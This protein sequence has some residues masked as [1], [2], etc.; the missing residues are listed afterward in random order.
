M[1]RVISFL[2]T[3]DRTLPDLLELLDLFALDR[4]F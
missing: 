3:Q 4:S 2:A 1:F